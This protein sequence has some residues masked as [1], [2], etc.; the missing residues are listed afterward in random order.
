F[1]GVIS[2]LSRE[3]FNVYVFFGK[4]KPDEISQF[5]ERNADKSVSLVPPLETAR[6]QI[7]ECE[8]DMLVYTDIGMD[9]FTYFLAFSRLAPVQCVTWG[10]PDTTGIPNLD[11]FISC[12][13]FEAEGSQTQ[14]SESLV[15]MTHIPNYFY[16]PD[17][18]ELTGTREIIRRVGLRDDKR[19]YVVPQSL[20]KLHPD[21]DAVL[22]EILRRDSDGL[23]ILFKAKQ[24]D[25][26]TLL[27]DRFRQS[28]P[29]VAERIIFVP[30][31][32]LNNFLSF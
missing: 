31:L 26:S 4:K 5:I 15:R 18:V 29:G 3:L 9:P 22:G 19:L 24:E 7:A 13:D 1:R 32:S 10:H 28:I 25:L 16:R 12:E 27:M 14:Y 20:F 8:L 21:F 23:L 11:Y 30:R 17:A 2:N 6:E